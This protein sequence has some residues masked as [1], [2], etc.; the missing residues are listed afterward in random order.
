MTHIPSFVKIGTCAEG[1]LRICHSNW[2][3]CNVGITDER[4]L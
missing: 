1:V 4:Y 3:G 2:K